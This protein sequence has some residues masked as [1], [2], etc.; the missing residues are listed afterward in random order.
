MSATPADVAKR[1]FN[2]VWNERKA[3]TIAELMHPSAVG[4]TSAGETRGPAD[5]KERVW[6]QLTGAFSDIRLVME[7]LVAADR[8]VVIRWRV[9]MLHTGKALGIPPSGRPVSLTGLTWM[10]VREG[11]IVEGWDGWDATGMLVQ[12]GG[13]TLDPALSK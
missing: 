2:E 7:D 1:W 12:C 3:S 8:T 10:T 11:L 9:T 6:D 5:W 13:A 4:H